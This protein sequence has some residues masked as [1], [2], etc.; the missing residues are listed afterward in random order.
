MFLEPKKTIYIALSA[1]FDSR[2]V[3]LNS[4]ALNRCL[5]LKIMGNH[6]CYIPFYVSS[7][8]TLWAKQR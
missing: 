6:P 7:K 3:D 4:K 1:S 5:T 2:I 8:S